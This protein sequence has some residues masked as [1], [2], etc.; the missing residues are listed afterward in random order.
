[1]FERVQPDHD[2]G[3]DREAYAY[4]DDDRLLEYPRATSAAR[5]FPDSRKTYER[6]EYESW[7]YEKNVSPAVI[8][9]GVQDDS[10]YYRPEEYSESEQER[11]GAHRH[12]YT[13]PAEERDEL[14]A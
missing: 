6:N 10:R 4:D 5:S 14:D 9:R 12:I 3:S 11:A 7:V 2:Y 8:L 1:M 13:T